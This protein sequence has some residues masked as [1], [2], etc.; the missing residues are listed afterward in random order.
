MSARGLL[1]FRLHGQDD[2]TPNHSPHGFSG[3]LKAVRKR[4]V[5]V[6]RRGRPLMV[7]LS[8]DQYEGLQITIEILRDQAFARNLRRTV[9]DDLASGE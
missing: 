5:V 6:T 9:V 7:V 8:A 3:L 1:T 4:P 2:A